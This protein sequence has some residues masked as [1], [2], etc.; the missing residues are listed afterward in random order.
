MP[1]DSCPRC[2]GAMVGDGYTDVRHC[3]NVDVSDMCLEPVAGP[4][5]CNFTDENEEKT[6]A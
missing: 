3:E 5:Y 4:V 6:D 2:G 1:Y